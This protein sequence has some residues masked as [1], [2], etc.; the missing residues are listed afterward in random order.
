[1]IQKG[2]EVVGYYAI[3]NNEILT[4]FYELFVSLAVDKDFTISKQAYF[5]QDN[6]VEIPESYVLGDEELSCLESELYKNPR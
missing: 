3:H 6:Q 5:F 4:Q 2:S 1:M